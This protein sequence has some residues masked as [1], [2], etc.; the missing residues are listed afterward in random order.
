M[1]NANARPAQAPATAEY[2]IQQQI[3][4]NIANLPMF[5]GIPEKDTVTLKYSVSHV[6]QGVSTLG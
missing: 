2:C 6:D 5:N 1:D 3:N 4:D